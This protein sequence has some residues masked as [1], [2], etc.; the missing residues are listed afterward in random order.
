[1]G[2]DRR[3]AGRSADDHA[4]PEDHRE[5]FSSDDHANDARIFARGLEGSRSFAQGFVVGSKR[6]AKG[7]SPQTARHERRELLIR[8][9]TSAHAPIV[10]LLRDEQ[11]I[12]ALDVSGA[13][14]R[15]S[16]PLDV[17][18]ACVRFGR[19]LDL[20]ERF[21]VPRGLG[22]VLSRT[23]RQRR[24]S[25]QFEEQ[26][27]TLPECMCADGGPLRCCRHGLHVVPEPLRGLRFPVAAQDHDPRRLVEA[28]REA[29]EL[30]SSSQVAAKLGRPRARHHSGAA[31]KESFEEPRHAVRLQKPEARSAALLINS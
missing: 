18:D 11:S 23:G 19:G 22:Q 8:V 16:L 3:T 20:A 26:E 17:A 2:V 6:D 5:P 1:M 28:Q 27:R 12:E 7:L 14:Q 24:V 29:E 31:A 25:G 21:E 15:A 9:S 30:R 13:R 4:V 10:L